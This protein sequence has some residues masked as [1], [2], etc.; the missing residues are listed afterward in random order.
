MLRGKKNILIVV[1]CFVLLTSF[2]NQVPLN[3]LGK[4]TTMLQADSLLVKDSLLIKYVPVIPT[5]FQIADAWLV[6]SFVGNKMDSSFNTLKA[7][8]NYFLQKR[9][10]YKLYFPSSIIA[11]ESQVVYKIEQRFALPDKD[12]LFY[13]ILMLIFLF[14]F[15]NNVF[16]QYFSK[17]F[18][19]FSQSSLRMIQYREQLLQNSL[20]SLIINICFIL[21]FSLMST[22]LIFNRHLLA[23]SF[24]EGFF[25]IS[26]FFTFL[27]IGKYISLQIAGYV[28]NSKELVN[29]YVFVVFMINKVLGVLLVPFILVLAFAKPIFHPYAIGGAALIT[30]LLIL[31]RYLFSLTS[32]RNKLHISSFHFFLY[33]CAFEILPLTILYKFIVQYFGGIY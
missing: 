14:G 25:Y 17:L 3:D 20:G 1:G 11:R 28:F 21:S 4:D 7:Y 30:V 26:L 15:V 33:L 10:A 22:L 31:Y 16:P 23:L 24:W 19:Q 12:L 9:N 32:V 8:K 5:S 27:Y 18:K 6:Q 13:L 29:T 2:Q